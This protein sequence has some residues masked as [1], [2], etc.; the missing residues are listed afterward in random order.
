MGRIEGGG[1][2]GD[3]GSMNGDL[4]I[5][6]ALA[7]AAAP[8]MAPLQRMRGLEAVKRRGEARQRKRHVFAVAAGLS[9]CGLVAAGAIGLYVVRGSAHRPAG[10]PSGSPASL[11]TARHR[12]WI[13]LPGK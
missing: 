1:G 5:V 2:G 9:A 7:R 8:P 6:A 12:S 11:T 10:A 4:D 3:H 13:D